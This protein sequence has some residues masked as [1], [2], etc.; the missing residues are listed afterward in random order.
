MAPEVAAVR[1]ALF[2]LRPVGGQ[3]Q[4]KSWPGLKGESRVSKGPSARGPESHLSSVLPA[5][6]SAG[7]PRAREWPGANRNKHNTGEAGG[8]GPEQTSISSLTCR[9]RS[10][11]LVSD[12]WRSPWT[13][14]HQV[15]VRGI[16][17]ARILEW[18]AISFSRRS[19]Q[20]RD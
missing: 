18:I 10:V 14:A 8:G 13:V 6:S 15:P 2:P 19:S 11:S 5:G 17:Q 4:G 9:V 16:L 20:P 12:S 7:A 1:T 3:A